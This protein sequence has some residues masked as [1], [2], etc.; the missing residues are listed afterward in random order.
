MTYR[1]VD[2]RVEHR[3]KQQLERETRQGLGDKKRRDLV[4]PPTGLPPQKRLLRVHDRARVG[5]RLQDRAE[6]DEPQR[7]DAVKHPGRGVGVGGVGGAE[8]EVGR[9]EEH[10]EEEVLGQ[11][12]A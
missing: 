3:S 9:P 6:N 2:D 12:D 1:K 10:A 8:A 11:L 4:E 5:R 7:G